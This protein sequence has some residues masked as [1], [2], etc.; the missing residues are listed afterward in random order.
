M[1]KTENFEGNCHSSVFL[2]NKEDSMENCRKL[3]LDNSYAIIDMG[4]PIWGG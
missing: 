3:L 4:I 1:R 2:K